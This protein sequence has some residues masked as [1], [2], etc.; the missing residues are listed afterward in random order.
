V[1]PGEHGGRG[2]LKLDEPRAW[3]LLAALF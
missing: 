1:K 3:P 2:A